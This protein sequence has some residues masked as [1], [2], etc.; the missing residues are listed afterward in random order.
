MAT[1]IQFILGNSTVQ[2]EQLVASPICVFLIQC[3]LVA[4]AI[5][6]PSIMH[7]LSTAR[8]SITISIGCISGFHLETEKGTF[9][10]YSP[11]KQSYSRRQTILNE[12]KLADELFS[13]LGPRLYDIINDLILALGH[14][15]AACA[16]C[17]SQNHLLFGFLVT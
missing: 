10:S 8:I 2:C 11:R 13:E 15:Q 17:C 16:S 12:E 6:S 3:C 5:I 1:L 14:R 9:Y 7:C 4:K